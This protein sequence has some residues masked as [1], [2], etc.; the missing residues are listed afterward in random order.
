M[1]FVVHKA[2]SELEQ[3]ILA[4]LYLARKG[5]LQHAFPLDIPIVPSSAITVTIDCERMT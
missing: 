3:M 2:T 1:C 4:T 5:D